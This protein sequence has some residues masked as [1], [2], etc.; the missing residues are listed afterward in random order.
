MMSV[1]KAPRRSRWAVPAALVAAVVVTAVT[2]TTAAAASPSLPPRTPAQLLTDMA[3]EAGSPTPMS[4]QLVVSAG[5]GIPQLPGQESPSSILS[6]LTGSHTISLSYADRTHFR[7]ALPVPLGE[8][9]VIRDGSTAWIWQS[10]SDSVTQLTLPA[11]GAG[12]YGSAGQAPSG[13]AGSP[14]PGPVTPQQ[15][16]QQLLTAIGPS[17]SFTTGDTTTVAGEDAYQ[18]VVTPQQ[19]GSLIG[20]VVIALDASHPGVVLGVQV[21]PRGAQTAA[22]SEQFQSVTFATPD[23]GTFQF[24]PPQ[25]ATVHTVTPSAMSGQPASPQPQQAAT[26]G[27]KVIGKDWL[28]VLELP[29]SALNGLASGGNVAGAVGQAAQSAAAGPGSGPGG[30]ISGADIWSA[31]LKSATTVHGSFGSGQLIHTSLLNVL[32]A[33]GHVFIGAVDPSVL[34]SAAAQAG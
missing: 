31:L 5:L 3:T 28:S 8:T 4:G 7:L 11:N 6:L 24:T 26:S 23:A 29:S 20:S 32:I 19:R 10:S 16:V 12:V 30:G 13:T 1:P 2:V 21:F 27:V 18:L 34:S 9:D 15:A 33:N 25:G 14:S 22:W 17:T